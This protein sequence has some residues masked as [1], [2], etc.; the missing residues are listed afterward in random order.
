MGRTVGCHPPYQCTRPLLDERLFQHLSEWLPLGPVVLASVIET[1]GATPRKGGSRMLIAADRTAFSVGGGAAEA[2]VIEAANALLH[3]DE[4]S[5]SVDIDLSGK[6]GAVGVCG[7]AMRLSLRRWQGR[8][9][10]LRAGAIAGQLR[11]GLCVVLSASDVGSD[12]TGSV[13]IPNVRLLIVGGGHCALALHELARFLDFE[14]WVYDERESCFGQGQFADATR[15]SGDVQQLAQALQT[16]RTVFAVLLNRD[17]VSDVA[18]LSVL[19]SAPPR[20]IGMMGSRKRI[21]EVLAAL[22]PDGDA[23]AHLQAPVGLEIQAQTPHEIAVSILA[24]LIVART[25]L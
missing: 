25:R 14:Q 11:A 7:G 6:P 20:F 5:A 4:I 10:A 15:L 18:A 19:R 1:R 13:A 23:L 3:A 21:A 16:E 2:R 12:R 17:F 8:D 9:D 22:P 24:Q